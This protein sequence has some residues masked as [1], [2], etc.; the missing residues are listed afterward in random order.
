M[1]F[2]VL[3]KALKLV[4]GFNTKLERFSDNLLTELLKPITLDPLGALVIK[5]T[6]KTAVISFS[7]SGQSQG[8]PKKGKSARDRAKSLQAQVSSGAQLPRL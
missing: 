6:A 8:K 5:K 7:K 1:P 2:G 4:G 3:V